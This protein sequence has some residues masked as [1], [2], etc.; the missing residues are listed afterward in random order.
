M[1][2][3]PPELRR[4]LHA[5]EQA[6]EQTTRSQA[7]SPRLQEVGEVLSV[8]PGVVHVG[9]LRGVQSEEILLFEGGVEGM[10]FNLDRREVG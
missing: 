5:L 10:A 4:A 3:R 7:P 8:G 2:D 6:L 1:P 9:G